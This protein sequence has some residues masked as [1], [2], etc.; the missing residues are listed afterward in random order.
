MRLSINYDYV[1]IVFSDNDLTESND[2]DVVRDAPDAVT[3]TKLPPSIGD[4]I[5]RIWLSSSIQMVYKRH[6]EFDLIENA[7]YFLNQVRCWF[8]EY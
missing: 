2:S 7:P 1:F 6:F 8:V 4:V 5:S 3:R